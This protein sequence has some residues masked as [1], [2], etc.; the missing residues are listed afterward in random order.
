MEG[1]SIKP[2]FP[3]VISFDR[4]RKF[5]LADLEALQLDS[6]VNLR[7]QLLQHGAILLRNFPIH[8]VYDFSNFIKALNLGTFVNYVGG[9]SPR[10]KVTEGIYTSTEAPPQF[11]IP[12]H[13]EL[14]YL[15]IYPKHIYFFCEIEPEFHGETIIAD[16]R[17]IY[18][19]LNTELVQRFQEKRLTYISHYYK[20]NAMM[21][22]INSFAY[23]HKSWMDVFETKQKA[24]VEQFCQ[25]NEIEW[26]WLPGDWIEL[27]HTRPAVMKHPDTQETVWFNQAHLFDFNPKLLGLIN[28]MAASLVYFRRQTRLHEISFANGDKIPREDLYHI[29]DVLKQHSVAHSWKKGDVLILDNILCMHGRACFRGKRRILTAMTS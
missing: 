27:K 6:T 22:L 29:L 8:A 18:K 9:D 21:K 12:L 3:Y 28:F 23:S 16:A 4:N 15:S 10:N 1:F 25:D 5:E 2:G 26:R 17:T 7:Q 24:H 11:Y 19:A 13:Q 20:E 14:S